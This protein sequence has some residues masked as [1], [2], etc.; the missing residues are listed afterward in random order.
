[1]T[2]QKISTTLAAVLSLSIASALV[3]PPGWA[4]AADSSAK[5]KKKSSLGK[6]GKKAS[7]AQK[8]NGTVASGGCESAIK[9]RLQE[10]TVALANSDAK[11]VSAM[12]VEDGTYSNE[13]GQE[14]KGRAALEKRFA[15]VFTSEGRL[16]LDF[17]PAT[18]RQLADNVATVDGFVK[19][20]DEVGGSPDTRFSM[21]FQKQGDGTW[22]I[23]SASE[24]PF[25]DS[26]RLDHLKPLAW[27][28]GDWA[29]E[30]DGNSMVVKI[31]WAAN[32][33]FIHLRYMIK[34]AGSEELDSQQ[35]IGWDPRRQ[36]IVSWI[37]DSRGGFGSGTWSRRDN[38][39]LVDSEGVDPEG[40]S[41][42]ATNIISNKSA[43]SFSWQSVNRSIEGESLSDTAPLTINRR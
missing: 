8:S 32:K 39:W 19:F 17:I 22:S 21:V 24:T 10:L 27:L 25:V 30:K 15:A 7:A 1:M 23:V 43:N 20:K 29:V 14:W 41:T 11:A 9:N 36:Q 28:I 3:C 40:R 4:E 5:A 18:V 31:E 34:K 2:V 33:K 16:L 37:F 12:W 42:A 6:S 38:Q 26:E 35:I 13:I